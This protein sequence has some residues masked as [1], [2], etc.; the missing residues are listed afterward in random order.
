MEKIKGCWIDEGLD[1]IREVKFE[2]Q[3]IA[4]IQALSKNNQAEI[5]R[6]AI[7]KRFVDGKI[8]FDVNTVLTQIIQIKL[9][10]VEWA[11]DRE[12]TEK[13]IGKLPAYYFDT[14]NRAVVKM[15]DDYAE[16]K[17]AIMGNLHKQSE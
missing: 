16:R 13:N 8:E 4:K 6:R 3:V 11:F 10:L 17:P 5:E 7:K 12:I 14:L 1:A 9:M 2:G 15:I